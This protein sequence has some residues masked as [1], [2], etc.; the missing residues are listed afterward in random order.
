MKQVPIGVRGQAEA[1]VAFEHTL[2]SHHAE[3]P[4]V[5]STPDMIRLMETAAFHACSRT[6]KAMK[7][8][9]ER[10][11]TSSIERPVVSVRKSGRRRR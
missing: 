9:W 1:T 10:P 7:S 5:F 3:L 8:R 11:S 4:P 6:V 2:T